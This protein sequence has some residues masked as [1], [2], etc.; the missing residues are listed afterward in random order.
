M[1]SGRY[2]TERLRRHWSQNRDGHCLLPTCWETSEDL[3]HILVRCP[4][5]RQAR[6]RVLAMWTD[7]LATRPHLATVVE[8][9]TALPGSHLVQFLV[10]P[11]VLPL[12]I[13]LG[14]EHGEDAINALF[15]L[16]RTFCY[17]IHRCRLKHLGLI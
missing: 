16:T 7:Y 12:V 13:T 15:Y 9:Y 4:A 8:H 3:E 5:H 11:S 1:L 17:S 6:A 10:D 2:R 14:Q